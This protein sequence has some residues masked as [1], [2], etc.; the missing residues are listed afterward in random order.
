MNEIV[1]AARRTNI[2]LADI[3]PALQYAGNLMDILTTEFEDIEIYRKMITAVF[4]DSIN[5]IRELFEAGNIADAIKIMAELFEKYQNKKI[6]FNDCHFNRVLC[7]A[8]KMQM[9][10]TGL[11][12]DNVENTRKFFH[13]CA[14]ELID[15]SVDYL[16]YTKC[17]IGKTRFEDNVFNMFSVISD[18]A[19]VSD[20]YYNWVDFQMEVL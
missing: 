14:V 6:F 2:S 9:C 7:E 20:R 15:I 12:D 4:G 17:N 16:D 5:K 13:G 8:H 11:H 19:N 18:S 3:S 1:E 10:I